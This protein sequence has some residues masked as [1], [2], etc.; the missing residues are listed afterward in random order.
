MIKVS[1]RGENV[2]VEPVVARVRLVRVLPRFA[3][4]LAAPESSPSRADGER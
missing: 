1:I 2:V 4:F 3:D